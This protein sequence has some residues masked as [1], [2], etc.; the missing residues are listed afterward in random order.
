MG[1]VLRG[2]RSGRVM[3]AFVCGLDVRRDSTY[4]T[5]SDPS[6]TIVNQTRINNERVLSYLSAFNVGKVGMEASN[7]VVPSYR[8]LTRGG[9]DVVVLHLEKTS[10]IEEAKIKSDRVDPRAIAE[11]VRLDALIE[12]DR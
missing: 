12:I 6:E 1:S 2:G 10:F 8:Q 5:I 3:S 9:F 7:Q 11:L 4:A